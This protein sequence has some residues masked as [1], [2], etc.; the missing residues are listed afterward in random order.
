[1]NGG[2]SRGAAGT[3]DPTQ[4]SYSVDVIITTQLV[5]I[6]DE[7]RRCQEDLSAADPN[8]ERVRVPG[9]VGDPPTVTVRVL[10][11]Y[12]GCRKWD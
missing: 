4:G 3:G 10:T 5:T 2:V 1:M 12:W 8:T 9:S 11:N 6:S 7:T